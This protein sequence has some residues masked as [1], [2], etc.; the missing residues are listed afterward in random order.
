MH[1]RLA[2]SDA[3]AVNPLLFLFKEP[4][5]FWRCYVGEIILIQ[6]QFRIMAE[7]AAEITFAQED[8]RA[9]LSR[10]IYQ[11][12]LHHTFDVYVIRFF[13]YCHRS[14]PHASKSLLSL[15]FPYRF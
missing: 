4:E 13:R 3:Y 9:D 11:R 15:L 5:E 1:C 8:D 12:G 7:F 2:S 14:S 6:Y 10:I